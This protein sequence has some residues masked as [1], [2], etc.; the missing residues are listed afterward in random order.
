MTKDEKVFVFAFGEALL[1]MEKRNSNIVPKWVKYKIVGLGH[2]P[3]YVISTYPDDVFT[4]LTKNGFRR[5][6]S[7]VWG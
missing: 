6:V 3:V 7:K 2:E 1:G 5:K 4:S